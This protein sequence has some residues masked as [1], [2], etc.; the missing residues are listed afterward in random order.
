MKPCLRCG[1][2]PGFAKVFF[3][4]EQEVLKRGMRF[5]RLAC[6]SGCAGGRISSGT[7]RPRG[8]RAILC[9]GDGD[10]EQVRDGVRATVPQTNTASTRTVPHAFL[11]QVRGLSERLS[12]AY[13]DSAEH[14]DLIRPWRA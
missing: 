10:G 2:Q 13:A 3:Y 4:L 9:H 14:G 5:I 7:A 12:H 6:R 8:A 1:K 11:A